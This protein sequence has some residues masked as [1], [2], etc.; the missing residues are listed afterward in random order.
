MHW[1]KV[2]FP[3][4]KQ[5]RDKFSILTTWIK[6]VLIFCQI[7]QCGTGR[8]Q[9]LLKWHFLLLFLPFFFFFFP[10]LLFIWT[11]FSGRQTSDPI[12]KNKIHFFKIFYFQLARL[13]G[14]GRIERT[15]IKILCT[16]WWTGDCSFPRN[17]VMGNCW[18]S[19]SHF[20][21]NVHFTI[22][23]IDA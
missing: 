9:K 16:D 11:F 4:E 18:I 5:I 15:F 3:F 6:I 14:I 19:C 23:V 2:P 7:R 21:N 1:L 13:S 22:F 8:R 20:L 10:L 12:K 17:Q